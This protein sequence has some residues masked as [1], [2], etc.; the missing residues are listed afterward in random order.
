M[1]AIYFVHA[2]Y[3]EYQ[4]IYIVPASIYCEVVPISSNTKHLWLIL[5]E[6]DGLENALFALRDPSFCIL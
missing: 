4:N 6:R 3:I 5:R 2:I 1:A